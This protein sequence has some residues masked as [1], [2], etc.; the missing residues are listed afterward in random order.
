MSAWEYDEKLLVLRHAKTGYEVDLEEMTDCPQMLDWIFQ[1]AAKSWADS[2]V[3]G[4][5]VLRLMELFDPQRTLCSGGYER[6]PVVPSEL[7]PRV[8]AFGREARRLSAL[9]GGQ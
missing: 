1:V 6:G 9:I 5:L 8:A 3:V 2:E 4:E 7:L